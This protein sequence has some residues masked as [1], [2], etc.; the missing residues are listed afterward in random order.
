MHR[1]RDSSVTTAFAHRRASRSSRSTTWPAFRASASSTSMTFGSSFSRPPGPVT[2]P[3]A[4]WIVSASRWKPRSSARPGELSA[5][6]PISSRCEKNIK[7]LS[8]NDEDRS[9]N[10]QDLSA[11]SATA[12]PP[13]ENLPKGEHHA[14]KETQDYGPG[15]R[16]AYCLR[17]RRS[18]G[19]T[20]VFRLARRDTGRRGQRPWLPG[21]LPDR[22]ARRA[23]PL[24]RLE[25]HR[26]ARRQRHLGSGPREQE[27]AVRRAAE[28][29][30]AGKLR[31][32]R[33]LPDPDLR[34]L[35]DVR[36]GAPGPRNL[37]RRSRSRR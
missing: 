29:R 36:V 35:P 14:F 5:C 17:I 3:A 19:G 7:T 21:R 37:R 11:G 28:P 4:G 25:P 31:G 12:W 24:H 6:S 22:V 10:D 27:R 34:Q 26:Y 33:F 13:T 15:G 9:L 8:R 1:D 2:S 20:Q 30:R 32:R 16:P 23:Q 18:R